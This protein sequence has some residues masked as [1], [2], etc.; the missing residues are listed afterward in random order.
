M[1]NTSPA[2]D[3][4]QRRVRRYFAALASGAAL[5]LHLAGGG[6]AW[7]HYDLPRMT[8]QIGVG[9]LRPCPLLTI[10]VQRGRSQL[11]VQR[12]AHRIAR[13][14]AATQIED[15]RAERRDA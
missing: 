9:E 5:Q 13:R 14:I 3:L 7:T 1:F 8:H 15:A 2:I 4:R 11:R 10:I 12:L 6:P